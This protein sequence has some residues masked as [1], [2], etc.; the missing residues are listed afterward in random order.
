MWKVSHEG[1]DKDAKCRVYRERLKKLM[2]S[3]ACLVDSKERA[4]AL[5]QRERHVKEQTVVLDTRTKEVEQAEHRQKCEVAELTSLEAKFEKERSELRE[6][7]LQCQ[8]LAADV[9]TQSDVNKKT[10]KQLMAATDSLRTKFVA[11]KIDISSSV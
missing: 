4:I 5:G 8:A 1:E 2:A 6:A 11:I 9:E 3:H 10:E 7:Q